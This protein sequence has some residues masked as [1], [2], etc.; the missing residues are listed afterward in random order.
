MS[1]ELTI[2]PD[3][4]SS[5]PP[6]DGSTGAAGARG[7]AVARWLS[8][9]WALVR[10][11]LQRVFVLPVA[12]GRLVDR[13]WTAG[14]RAV[15]WVALAG[16]VGLTLLTLL[17]PVVRSATPLAVQSSGATFPRLVLP[18][19]VTAVSGTLALVATA[20]LRLRWWAQVATFLVLAGILLWAPLLTGSLVGLAGVLLTMVGFL[21]LLLVRR[22]K[23]FRAWEFVVLLMVIGTTLG[24]VLLAANPGADTAVDLQLTHFL[25]WYL[26]MFGLATPIAILAGVAMAEI[27]IATVTWSVSSVIRSLR[28][29]RREEPARFAR[30]RRVVV[31]TVL[32]GVTGFL[33]VR[34][35]LAFPDADA[36]GQTLRGMGMFGLVLLLLVPVL[37]RG[38]RRF[39]LR[40]DAD[41]VID[42]WSGASVPVGLL[43]ALPFLYAVLVQLVGAFGLA[44]VAIALS[45]LGGSYQAV[46]L[47]LLGAVVL[48]GLAWR[49]ATAGQTPVAIAYAAVA[50]VLVLSSVAS[51]LDIAASL[52]GLRAGGWCAAVVTLVVLVVRRRLTAE[53]A[54]AL[55]VVLVVAGVFDFRKFIYEPLT[56]V[57]GLAG[58][59]FGLVIGLL[60]RLLTD[61][62][63]THT[64]SPGF[65]RA[66]RVMLALANLLFG[67]LAIAVVA[68]GGGTLA[69]DL[70]QFESI[71][72]QLVGSGLWAGVTAAALVLAWRGQRLTSDR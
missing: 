59:S 22:R 53:R 34:E 45:R 65:P 24:G 11:V 52:S 2:G 29:R 3:A 63:W 70:E 35:I 9:A 31:W 62:G 39:G 36:A 6:T 47:L 43:V 41:D 16:F 14:L 48:Y 1:E 7:A 49:R 51:W 67:A 19:L 54:V 10:F 37:W 42:A 50:A 25:T 56:F 20:A 5:A 46:G 72:D 18:V 28:G 61:N 66:S 32:V 64:D 12:E 13:G 26:P 71:G 68:L 60:W 38:E 4:A 40:A 33:L 23:P 55:A 30:G 44:S 69:L 8:E 57:V 15:V 17:A 27:T 21:V 58:L